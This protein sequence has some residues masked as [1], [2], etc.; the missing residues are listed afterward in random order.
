MNITIEKAFEILALVRD[1]QGEM[2]LKDI[3]ELLNMNKTT[4]F[5][6]VNTLTSLNL[7][8]N[9]RGFYS[10]GLGLFELG[11]KVKIQNLM[12]KVCHP[13]LDKL[14]HEVNETVNLAQFSNSLAVYL[15][16]A[17][18]RRSL[19]LKASVG[20][21]LPIYCT[22]LGKSMLSI[23]DRDIADRL[24]SNLGMKKLTKH[25]I[26]D[27]KSLI[28]H[29]DLVKENGYSV[30]NEEYEEGLVCIAVPLK[31]SEIN[32]IGGISISGPINRFNEERISFFAQR[33]IKI[34]NEVL[35]ILQR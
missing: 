29:L 34:R 26:I 19:Q 4:A 17:E 31:V 12:V 3:Y 6:Y 21:R 5:R 32:F 15:D 11:I 33:L 10:L 8:I 22:G 9:D 2:R 30:D 27:P 16:K 28:K 24:I 20:D 7:L 13:V 23:L 14:A 35:N 1:H 18:S 25:T